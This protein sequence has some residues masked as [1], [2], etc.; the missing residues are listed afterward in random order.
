MKLCI[1]IARGKH[2]RTIYFTNNYKKYWSDNIEDAKIYT[3]GRA[4]D[5]LKTMRYNN[6]SMLPI[7]IG[8]KNEE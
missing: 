7:Y 1:I 8:Q 5:R 3:V 2:K 6:P 4:K